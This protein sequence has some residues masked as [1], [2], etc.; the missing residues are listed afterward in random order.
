M[1]AEVETTWKAARAADCGE[2][3]RF[4][5]ERRE[6]SERSLNWSAEPCF[7]FGFGARQDPKYSTF[8][9][10]GIDRI[11]MVYCTKSLTK[12]SAVYLLPSAKTGKIV[13]LTYTEDTRQKAVDP[14][15]GVQRD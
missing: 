13:G 1:S 4:L 7:G 6:S 5:A 10:F 9:S 2:R 11:G 15:S 12:S 3:G 8:I 14:H